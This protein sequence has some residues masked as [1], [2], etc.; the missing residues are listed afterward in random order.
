MSYIDDFVKGGF[1]PLQH[2]ENDYDLDLRFVRYACR[3]DTRDEEGFYKVEERTAEWRGSESE[4]GRSEGRRCRRPGR[5]WRR[6]CA[7][8]H[9]T[10]HATERDARVELRDASRQAARAR[11]GR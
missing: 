8:S 9:G 3:V 4:G 2:H 7:R 1:W 11:P 6:R 10:A 5:R